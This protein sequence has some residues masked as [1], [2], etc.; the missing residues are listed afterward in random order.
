MENS[1]ADRINAFAQLGEILNEFGCFRELIQENITKQS[2]KNP[3]FIPSFI[4]YSLTAIAK[5]LNHDD[6][7]KLQHHYSIF[8]RIDSAKDE[9]IA[10]ISAGNIP[11]AGFHDFFSVLVSGIRYMGKLSSHDNMM[12]PIIAEILI[13]I[14]PPFKEKILFV[15][16]ISG[17][18]KIITT[19]SNNSARYFEYY[20][21]KYPHILRKNRNSL[22]I[23]SGDETDSQLKALYR[24]IFL[25]F[26]LGCR[27]VSM[28]FVPENYDFNRFIEIMNDCGKEI[29]MHHH[30]LNNLDYQKTMH[31]MN[32]VSFIDAGIALL[33]EKP[34]LNSPIGIIHWQYYKKMEEVKQ[35]IT[36]ERENIQCVVS[37]H[38]AIENGIAFGKAQNPDI[39]DF[40]DNIDTIKWV[41]S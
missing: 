41:I 34:Q 19:G 38:S 13:K 1:F 21:G 5:M 2:L 31:L 28:L 36:N 32:S 40:A 12:L 27:S 39:L 15:E 37:T 17:F 33:S 24:D 8:P 23:L 14:Y 18:D 29:A 10:V 4:E 16:K 20:F 35:F 11:L 25:Y 26:G 3:W 9:T 7:M 30:Y 22:A 6:L